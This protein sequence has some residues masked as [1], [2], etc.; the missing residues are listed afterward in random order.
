MRILLVAMLACAIAS[1]AL[2]QTVACDGTESGGTGV[3]SCPGVCDGASVDPGSTC[4][5]DDQCLPNP[6]GACILLDPHKYAYPTT[7]NQFTELI[8]GTEDCEGTHYSNWCD[9]PEWRHEVLKT[10][11]LQ[12]FSEK[13]PHGQ[14]SPGPDGNCPCVIRWWGPPID[15]WIF[16]YDNKSPSHDVGWSLTD[17]SGKTVEDWMQAV[18]EGAGPV[19]APDWPARTDI[20][21][22]SEWGLAV[23]ALLVLVAGSRV[24]LRRRVARA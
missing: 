17:L 7:G 14:V 8:I 4:T 9:P 11:D 10:G 19:H 2:A 18:G 13:T 23:M 21:T 5:N 1:P 3:T 24:L 20:P 22:V 16:G 12:H 15:S 6:G